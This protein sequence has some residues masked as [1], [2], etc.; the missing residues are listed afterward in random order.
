MDSSV[1]CQ[2]WCEAIF[3]FEF[4]PFIVANLFILFLL[5]CSGLMSASEVAFFSLTRPEVDELRESDNPS[6]RR[7]AALLDKPRYLLTTILITNNLVN[8]GVVISSYFVTKLAFNFR[9][10]QLGDFV[11]RS[12]ALEFIWNVI[13]VTFFLVLLGEATPKVFATYHK[14]KIARLMS[15]V[16]VWLNRVLFPVNYVLV[17]ST[18]FIEKRLKRHNTEIDIEEIHKAIE[19]TV[20]KKESTQDARLLKGIVHFG[21]ITVKQIMRPRTEVVAVDSD[22]KFTELMN[23]VRENGYSRYPVCQ[24]TL[25]SITGVLYVKDLLEH[26]DR[27]DDFEWQ[28]LVRPPFYVPETKMI[29]DLLRDMQQNRRHLAIVVDE[30]GGTSGIVTLEDVLEEVVGDIKD[31]F[32]EGT[33]TD[34]R[35][36]DD[37]NFLFEG[38]TPL[39]DACRLM[40]IDPDTFDEVRG[41]AETLAGLVLEA[42]GRIPRNG[43]ELQ[44]LQYKFTILSVSNNRIEKIKVTR[45]A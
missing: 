20:E 33:D 3:Q 38:R 12:E 16:F 14:L 42:K 11:L 7:V 44:L 24:D 19:L 1:S 45:E 29:D 30:Y 32:D 2:I 4:T 13:I 36:L 5:L 39:V 41:E 21:N 40:E 8:I 35:K 18:G 26:L 25:D 6:D 27:S 22:M 17:N 43:E 10:I 28:N 23:F 37:K 34:F 9:D 31:E 15:G